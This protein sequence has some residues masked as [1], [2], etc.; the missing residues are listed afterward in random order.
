MEKTETLRRALVQ[1][2]NYAFCRLLK[3]RVVA[4]QS[5]N[6]AAYLSALTNDVSTL[7]TDYLVKR[8]SMIVMAVNFFGALAMILPKL[9]TQM[10]SQMPMTR[11]MSCS[12]SS[13]AMWN[14]SRIVVT[15]T[16][17]GSLLRQYDEILVLKDGC[18]SERGTFD[19]LLARKGYFYALYTVAQ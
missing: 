9:S 15:H 12:M 2:K 10:P 8:I 19:D 18:V 14:M 1:Y 11:L 5:E 4:F 7:E 16:L 6:S 3:K 17:D 13:T